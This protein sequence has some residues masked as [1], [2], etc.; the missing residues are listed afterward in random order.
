M[1]WLEDDDMDEEDWD[2]DDRELADDAVDRL[3]LLDGVER[4]DWDDSDELD[5]APELDEEELFRVSS[6]LAKSLTE[7]PLRRMNGPSTI[8]WRAVD[9]VADANVVARPDSVV[10]IS[11]CRSTSPL[12]KSIPI[13]WTTTGS[14]LENR[15][16]I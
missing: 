8:T 13:E 5:V 2:E 9:A 10:V 11:Y 6:R 15:S 14:F 12:L 4:L 7:S 1:L 3:E 16:S